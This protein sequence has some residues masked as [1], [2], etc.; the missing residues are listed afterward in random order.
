MS[1]DILTEYPVFKQDIEDS[2]KDLIKEF[3]VK[4]LE[5]H[6]G[7]Y[8]LEGEKCSIRFTY[9]RGDVSC[10]FKQPSEYKDSPGYNVWAVSKFLY[11]TKESSKI[12]F[13]ARSQLFEY[14]DIIQSKLKNVL[15]G[16]F[17]WLTDFTK[18]KERENKILDFVL[19]LDNDNLIKKKFWKGDLSWQEDI[20][21][22]LNE[23][24]I[25]L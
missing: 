20:D 10:H 8:L 5:L 18:E 12:I 2:F 9:D 14:L 13:D 6:R 19:G 25:K 22:Y 21:R 24:N 11:S 3:E 17:S 15:R 23:N 1:I 16:D 4:L 7:C